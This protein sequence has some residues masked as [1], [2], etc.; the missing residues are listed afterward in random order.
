MLRVLLLPGRRWVG[1][2][3]TKTPNAPSVSSD[4]AFI[5]MPALLQLLCAPYRSCR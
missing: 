4:A 3:A 5:F 2:A 1:A